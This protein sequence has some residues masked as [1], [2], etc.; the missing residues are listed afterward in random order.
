[1]I[2][3]TKPDV[4]LGTETWLSDKICTAEV[5]HPEL[6]Y[7]VIHRD[8]KGDAHEGVLIAAKIHLSLNNLLPYQLVFG[9]HRRQH[10]HRPP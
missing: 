3:S 10:Q 2:E 7:D 9:T 5:F 1:M 4:I 8:R 6:W